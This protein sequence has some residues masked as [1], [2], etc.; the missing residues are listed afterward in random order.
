MKVTSVKEGGTNI[1]VV[2]LE[3]N[4]IQ[5]L[6]GVKARTEKYKRDPWE[7]YTYGGG[8]AYYNEKGECLGNNNYIQ[9][10]IDNYRRSW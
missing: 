8:G 7:T 1:Y 10:A 6:F 5:R 2:H 3:P 4:F 9:T